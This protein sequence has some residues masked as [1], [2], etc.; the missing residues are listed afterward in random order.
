MKRNI[1]ILVV[2]ILIVLIVGAGAWVYSGTLHG[3]K[4]N[5]VKNLSLP[6]A[7]VGHGLING[8][9]LFQRYRL[10]ESFGGES[11]DFNPTTV[12][13]EILGQMVETSKLE[14]LARKHNVKAT[15]ESVD[16]EYKSLLSAYGAGNESQF[17]EQLQ[18]TYGLNADE[19]K[20]KVLRPSVLQ[21]SLAVW[22]NYQRNL[23]EAAYTKKEELLSKLQQGQSFD[24]VAK[25]YTQD[26]ATKQFAGD[27]GFVA[28]SELLPEFYPSL[29]N[30]KAGDRLEVVSRFG[31]HILNVVEIDTGGA[32]PRYHLQQIFVQPSDFQKWYESET[33]NIKSRVFVKF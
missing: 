13:T 21:S 22:H 11:P 3:A 29:N 26:E 32:E 24:E 33:A 8:N 27:T 1:I 16:T 25:V 19:F 2:V 30:A 23:N 7:L 4:A 31:L 17:N 12:K 14:I 9:E 10:A 20:E 5:A 18:S 28:K 6:V 15:S